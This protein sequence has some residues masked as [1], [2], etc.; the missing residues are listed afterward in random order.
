MDYPIT[1]NMII[2][3]SA[4]R[5]INIDLLKLVLTAATQ[6]RNI[7]PAR[8]VILSCMSFHLVVSSM[9][10]TFGK[11]GKCGKRKRQLYRNEVVLSFNSSFR[12]EKRQK[13]MGDF[14][15]MQI[16]RMYAQHSLNSIQGSK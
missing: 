10:N 12:E 13:G 16:I 7:S 3:E 15:A 11:S 8:L 5:A 1:Q 6:V 9:V 14:I 2:F 4:A